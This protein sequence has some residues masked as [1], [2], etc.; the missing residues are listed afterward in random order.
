MKRLS[1]HN[2]WTL[3]ATG[4]SVP[5]AIASAPVPA[6]VP[7]TAHTDLLT[8]GLISDPYLDSNENDLVWAHRASWSYTT[9]V[10]IEPPAEGERV[11][12]VCEGLDTVAEITLGDAVVG[13][14]RNQHRT[15][16]FDVTEV[17]AAAGGQDTALTVAFRSALEAA[18][19]EVSRIGARPGAYDHPLNMVRKMACSFGWDWGPDL[20]TAGIWRP[21]GLERWRTAR[22]HSV[23]PLVTMDDDGAAHV[24][25]H[26]DVERSG[27]EDPS[28]VA[29]LTRLGDV[30]VVGVIPASASSTVVEIVVENPQ[31][32]WPRGYGEQPLH[33]LTVTLG[34]EGE[35]DTWHRRI[36]LR[37]VELDTTDDEAGTAFTLVING[38][39]VFV[40]GANWIPDDHLLTRITRDRLARRIDQAMDANMN[41]LRVWGGGIYESEDF[42]ELCDER[43]LLVW[44]DFLLA[45]FAY[46]EEEPHRSEFE[47]EAREHVTRLT[48]HPSLVMWNGGNENI[49]GHEDWDWKG[50]LGDLT[51]G[52]HYYYDLFPSIVAELAPTTPY[53]PGSPYSPRRTPEEMHP[54]DPDHGSHHQWDVWNRVD[55]SHYR[56]DIPRFCSE[57][58]F[59]GPPAWS[60]IER[61]IRNPDGSLP[62]KED[63]VWLVHQKAA[64]GNGKLDRG[65]A[66]HIGVPEDF[67][68][69][70]WATQLNQAR[71]VAHAITHYRSW[72]PRSAGSIVWQLND[73]WPVTS[74]AA[75]DG[76]E[77]PKPL[78]WSLRAAYA[79]RL[80]TVVPRGDAA[81]Q[82]DVLAVVNDTDETWG[83]SVTVRRELLD[84]TPLASEDLDVVVAPRSVTVLDL[85]DAVRLPG[86]RSR[87]IIV[88]ELDG[89]RAVHCFVE[90][91]E[92]RLQHSP[93]EVTVETIDDGYLVH[94]HATSLVKD[95]AL[96]VDRLDPDAEVDACLVTLPAGTD[97]TIRVRSDKRGLESHL[98]TH[99]VLRSANDLTGDRPDISEGITA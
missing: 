13:S 69:W 78:W 96:F 4:G 33:D 43:G 84:G 5:E 38:V 82:R 42:Y 65:L 77:R 66:P 57:F 24:A 72:W 44:Q 70:H 36:G 40:K 41:L 62:S 1:L 92:L 68:D 53:A 16:R 67:T 17:V 54:N 50:P 8:A 60:T 22:I 63:E 74:W 59:Q 81:D 25:V 35:L 87:E 58:G 83:G 52:S 26:V 80:L 23:R 89:E 73:C 3:S 20:Q 76:D 45:C 55:Y 15:H 71:A 48:A 12:L 31:L 86:D 79:D 27:L 46:P 39:P 88:A 9:Q 6:Q 37:T 18:E 32:W 85:P 21:I 28:D 47:A 51:W 30:D 19:E 29:V 98:V 34:D 75:I 10:R 90:D 49:W 56:D 97:T 7:G 64:D 61:A 11:D 14:T 94:V 93:L 2:G 91:I 95:L 99:P